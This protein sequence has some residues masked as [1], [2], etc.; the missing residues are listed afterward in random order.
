MVGGVAPVFLLDMTWWD[1][2]KELCHSE[3]HSY[4]TIITNIEKKIQL[5]GWIV[6]G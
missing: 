5:T 2:C 3:Y 1:D 4:P 6:N